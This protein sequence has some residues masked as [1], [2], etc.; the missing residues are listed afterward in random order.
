MNESVRK[1]TNDFEKWRTNTTTNQPINQSAK[2]QGQTTTTNKFNK[3]TTNKTNNTPTQEMVQHWNVRQNLPRSMFVIVLFTFIASSSD[4]PPSIPR[5]LSE[6][7]I[8]KGK[9]HIW[10]ETNNQNKQVNK[11]REKSGTVQ[12]QNKSW[13]LFDRSTNQQLKQQNNQTTNQSNEQHSERER[14]FNK[15]MWLRFTDWKGKVFWWIGWLWVL[16]WVILPR[17]FQ[18]CWLP[19][20]KKMRTTLLKQINQPTNQINQ[21]NFIIRWT[22]FSPLLCVG[23]FVHLSWVDWLVDWETYFQD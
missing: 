20:I 3:H 6:N 12:T 1:R 4:F 9:Q 23:V 5:L 13:C 17:H 15:M 22:F 7:K 10:S 11:Q 14:T 8:K 18:S 16:H 19:S 2:Q 21:I